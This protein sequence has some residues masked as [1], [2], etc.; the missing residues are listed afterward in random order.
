[1]PD[2]VEAAR[3]LKVLIA[4]PIEVVVAGLEARD[5]IEDIK[6]CDAVLWAE[7]IRKLDKQLD[8]VISQLVL[9]SQVIEGGGRA[10]S[11][12]CCLD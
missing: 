9:P 7:L 5:L 8:L 3:D 12:D 4:I 1:M 10:I 11:L 6:V 2:H